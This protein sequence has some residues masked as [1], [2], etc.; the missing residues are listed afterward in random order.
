[1]KY[2]LKIT[3]D[4]F[5]SG[6]LQITK[7]ENKLYFFDGEELVEELDSVQVVFISGNCLS[8]KGIWE[9]QIDGEIYRV[10]KTL[11]FFKE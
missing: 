8:L 2:R 4:L 11:F 7:A 6:E 10:E 1:M 9:T 3:D 5:I